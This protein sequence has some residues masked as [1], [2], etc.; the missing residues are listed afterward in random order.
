MPW[1]TITKAPESARRAVLK[2]YEKARRSFDWAAARKE[3]AGLPGGG[4]SIAHE[5]VDRHVVE[6]H[7]E[8]LAMRWIGRED[9]VRDVTYEDAAAILGG[10][11]RERSDRR[12]SLRLSL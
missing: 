9:E 8:R 3:L 12:G 6:G 1:D 5:A 11:V 4:L 2:N 10:P 7:G